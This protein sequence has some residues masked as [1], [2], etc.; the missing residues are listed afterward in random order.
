[1]EWGSDGV[2]IGFGSG[3]DG[4]GFQ[5]GSKWGHSIEPGSPAR[6]VP[7]RPRR[8][9][10]LPT[11][12]V[13]RKGHDWGCWGAVCGLVS[14]LGSPEDFRVGG[15][16]SNQAPI[17]PARGIRR[18]ALGFTGAVR[19]TSES[20]PTASRSRAPKAPRSGTD[21]RQ[22][23][24]LGGVRPAPSALRLAGRL[25]R[26]WPL[27][28]P[29]EAGLEWCRGRLLE[30]RNRQASSISHEMHGTCGRD[31]T[32]GPA[33]SNGRRLGFQAAR[34]RP[35]GAA[36]WASG[37]APEGGRSGVRRQLPRDAAG[38]NPQPSG[39]AAPP[40]KGG[41]G[42]AN[43]VPSGAANHATK[44][45]TNVPARQVSRPRTRLAQGPWV[46]AFSHLPG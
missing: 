35:A 36:G 17:R 8:R 32:K 14:A 38:E 39:E 25:P 7:M 46:T 20:G 33:G 3:L 13:C 28:R 6:M 24:G 44:C 22:R 2:R 16:L 23:Q 19:G 37:G 41:S 40:L 18:L 27:G 26:K 30:E 4:F 45:A 29:V 43:T 34:G 21:G 5:T 11:C 15:V 31:S 12:W 1:M 9:P 10:P 42:L